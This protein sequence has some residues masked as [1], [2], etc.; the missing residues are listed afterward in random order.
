MNKFILAIFLV[1][2]VNM[3]TSALTATTTSTNK[4][5]TS[6]TTKKTTKTTM[7]TTMKTT[8]TTT[9]TSPVN[10][11][12]INS[13][14]F[15]GNFVDSVTKLSLFNGFNVAG[16][17][18]DRRGRDNSSLHLNKG[19]MQMPNGKYFTGDFSTAVWLKIVEF[20]GQQSIYIIENEPFVDFFALNM[21]YPGNVVI[22][23]G[24]SL[25]KTNAIEVNAP[26]VGATDQWM[27][28]GV[29]LVGNK[30]SLYVNGTL[31][32][33]G[34]VAYPA[35]SSVVRT[36]CFLGQP[37]LALNAYLDDVMF[38]NRGLNASEMLAISNYY[39]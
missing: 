26:Y 10:K 7:K 2:I 18:A 8:I 11:E 27:H 3:S 19:Y 4:P 15:N 30:L 33:S 13:W 22:S 5:L 12:R 38:F 31:R 6:S 29:T 37:H 25:F 9:Q 20:V 21:P 39:N 17:V 24:A 36:N 34:R 32:Q 23:F 28:V 35:I 16:F 1:A 14:N